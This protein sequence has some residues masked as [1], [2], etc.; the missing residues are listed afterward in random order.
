VRQRRTERFLLRVFGRTAR[1]LRGSATAPP[2]R[3]AL[4]P[5]FPS[6]VL[7]ADALNRVAWGLGSAPPKELAVEVP[8]RF[9][10][11]MAKESLDGL[12]VPESHE[13]YLSREDLLNHCVRVKADE[14]DRILT[15]AEIVLVWDSGALRQRTVLRRAGKIVVIDPSFFREEEVISIAGLAY[16]LLEPAD[17]AKL[18]DASR[19]RYGE[20]LGRFMG[21]KDAYVFFTG[22]SMK[23]GLEKPMIRESVRLVC[24]S[25]VRDD[26]VVEKIH[27]DI[28]LFLDPAYH[29]G[30]SRYASEFRA[31]VVRALRKLPSTLCIVPERYAP[32]LQGE[33]R[34]SAVDRVIGMPVVAEGPFNLPTAE[35]V[36]VRA[37]GNILTQFM[38]PV[39]SAVA[40]EIHIVGADGRQGGE[41]GFWSQAPSVQFGSLL[42]SID[43]AH[44]S[45]AR[46][47]DHERYYEEHCRVTARMPREWERR[48]GK[49]YISET[50]SYVPALAARC[51]SQRGQ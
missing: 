51:R 50:P 23:E 12:A 16:S 36:F 44:P 9:P 19:K 32:L 29:F 2:R 30:V 25:I 40:K 1:A 3:L 8:V 42:W 6:P 7:L 18:Q 43:V 47:T 24:N 38:I 5:A 33:L 46:D 4:Y 11:Q 22:P 31:Q 35:K 27:P 20:L 26:T 15:D 28:I 39:A 37:T 10:W 45:L 14:A 17:R 21:I 41:K 49:S 48:Y 13:R 34:G